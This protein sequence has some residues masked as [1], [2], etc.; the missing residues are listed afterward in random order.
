MYN[1]ATCDQNKHEFKRIIKCISGILITRRIIWGLK[2]KRGTEASLKE[3]FTQK[4]CHWITRWHLIIH[5]IQKEKCWRIS[6]SLF[7]PEM[8]ANE[9]QHC[10]W[11]WQISNCIRWFCASW[12][13]T[14][15]NGNGEVFGYCLLLADLFAYCS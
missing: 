2:W 9:M 15:M 3:Q 4:D 12:T 11:I 13:S 7:F 5:W 10:F 1:Y 8:K 14:K 6:W